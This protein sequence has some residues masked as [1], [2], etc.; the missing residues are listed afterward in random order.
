MEY[1]SA[2]NERPG[3]GREMTMTQAEYD[4]IWELIDTLK[5]AWAADVMQNA[6]PDVNK[7]TFIDAA[8]WLE[9]LTKGEVGTL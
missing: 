4:Y 6:P 1:A 7:R 3:G 8:K 5:S 9:R 2:L